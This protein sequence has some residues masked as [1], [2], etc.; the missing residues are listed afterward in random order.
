MAPDVSVCI[1]AYN[2]RE[3]LRACLE[4]IRRCTR[5]ASCEVLVVDNAS[6]DGTAEWLGSGPEGV[7]AVCNQDNRGF[8]AATNQAV[9]AA[10]G[11]HVLLL[12]PDTEL[13]EG[14]IDRTLAFLRK[15]TPADAA[16]CRVLNGDGTVQRVWKGE[17]Y[18]SL[19]AQWLMHWGLERWV[20]ECR[21][22]LPGFDASATGRVGYTAGCFLMLR[23]DLLVRLGLLDERFFLYSEDSDLC[24]RVR[25][26]GGSVFYFA[27]AEVV[28][29]GGRSTEPVSEV[30]QR[31]YLDS[32]LELYRKHFGRTRAWL[33][34]AIVGSGALIRTVGRSARPGA[35]DT[36][37]ARRRLLWA[38]GQGGRRAR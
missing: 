16:T 3:P 27:G 11:E 30:A 15:Q 8:A 4:S 6:R 12:N 24:R 5:E 38:L 2:C 26:A 10:G 13:R 23:R 25:R 7:R 28:H 22:K 32:R 9:R 18:Y 33:F 34:R 29:H 31:L 14:A 37:V 20:G 19:R 21:E 35:G 36:G 1:V 17:G